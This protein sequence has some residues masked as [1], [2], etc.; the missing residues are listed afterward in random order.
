MYLV[1]KQQ[2]LNYK[3]S[4]ASRLPSMKAAWYALQMDSSV[5]NTPASHLTTACSTCMA[6]V[7]THLHASDQQ[8]LPDV[9]GGSQQ[10]LPPGMPHYASMQ[11]FLNSY[12]H[13]S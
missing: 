12:L 3:T 8:R 7:H 13:V 10:Q 2:R 5:R 1:H 11:L 6:T 4:P 9:A